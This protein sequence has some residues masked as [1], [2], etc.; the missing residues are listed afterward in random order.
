[1]AADI[2]RFRGSGDEDEARWDAYRELL[3]RN[4]AEDPP[5]DE[6][7]RPAPRERRAFG[8]LTL[9]AA[10]RAFADAE[11]DSL[12][13]TETLRLEI[14]DDARPEHARARRMAV[15]RNTRLIAAILA[16][17]AG[18]ILA[19]ALVPHHHSREPAVIAWSHGQSPQSPP[20]HA[21]TPPPTIAST[22]LPAAAPA[23]APAAATPP[24][25]PPPMAFSA[26]ETTDGAHASDPPGPSCSPGRD[27]REILSRLRY[28][29]AE[30]PVAK[31]GRTLLLARSDEQR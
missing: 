20:T 15:G 27:R 5:Q 8:P 11:P 19:A 13:S 17:T 2:P 28:C 18:I 31:G 23:S 1:M 22:P 30:A 16:L 25:A 29:G 4:A 6:H 21:A 14:P 24:S 9:E 12:W 26:V 7:D 3:R 10:E